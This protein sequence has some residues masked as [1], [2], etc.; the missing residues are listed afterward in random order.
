MV[1]LGNCGC[2]HKEEVDRKL[3]PLRADREIRTPMERTLEVHGVHSQAA[4]V[5]KRH[6]KL[7]PHQD[8]NLLRKRNVA[9]EP[10]VCPEGRVQVQRLRY[11]VKQVPCL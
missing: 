8:E 4:L 1:A 5:D 11:E 10:M 6:D 2:S 9:A 3:T 7:H